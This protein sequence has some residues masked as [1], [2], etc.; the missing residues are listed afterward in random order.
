MNKPVLQSLCRQKLIEYSMRKKANIK[1]KLTVAQIV[2]L[3]IAV[4]LVV[5]F[6]AKEFLITSDSTMN[7]YTFTKEGELVFTDSAG[8]QKAKIDIEIADDDYQREL[9]LMN[10]KSMQENQGML[11]IFPFERFQS[12]W[13]R[14]TFISLDMIFVDANKTIVTIHKNTQVLSD[15]SYPSSKPAKYVVEVVA[16]FTDKY[17]IK[18][19]DKIEW[20]GNAK[21]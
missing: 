2:A 15:Q 1:K 21:L 10:R 19:G 9:G 7:E 5:F 16:G 13:M 17:N 8:V 12:F 18:I 3:T 6:I 14:N 4:L 11:F 20:L